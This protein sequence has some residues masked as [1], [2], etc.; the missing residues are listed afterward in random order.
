M[1]SSK[2]YLNFDLSLSGDE[3]QYRAKVTESPAGHASLNFTLPFSKAE[4]NNFIQTTSQNRSNTRS[5]DLE[6]SDIQTV[7]TLGN[8]LFSCLITGEIAERF[9]TSLAIADTQDKGLRIRFGFSDAP[10]LIDIPWEL[11]FDSANKKYIGLSNKTPIIRKLDLATLPRL[12]QIHGCLQVL[13]M[14]SSPKD[15]SP[16][17]VE[18]EWQQINEA[19]AELQKTNRIALTKI[20]PSLTSLQS[21]LRNDDYHVFHYIGHGGFDKATNDGV[22]VLEDSERNGHIVTA[23]DLG[24][25]LHD[26]SSL[27]LAFLNSCHGARTSIADPFAGVGQTLLQ[28]GMPAVIA[29]QFEITDDAAITF[30]SELYSALTV[31]YSIER[32]VAEGRKAISISVNKIEWATPVLYTSLEG[33]AL[34]H[35]GESSSKKV[36]AKKTPESKDVGSS[37]KKMNTVNILKTKIL[38]PRNKNKAIVLGLLVVILATGVYSSFLSRVGVEASRIAKEESIAAKNRAEQKSKAAKE[39]AEAARLAE[40]KRLAKEKEAVRLANK[41]SMAVIMLAAQKSREEKAK[42]EAARLAESKRLIEEAKIALNKMYKQELKLEDNITLMPIPLG[43]F[44]MG[45]SS[46]SDREQPVHKVTLSKPFWMSKTEITI[47]QFDLYAKKTKQYFSYWSD[48]KSSPMT[49]VNWF[50]TQRYVKWLSKNNSLELQCRLPSEAEWEYAAR[51][52]SNTEYPWGNEIGENNANCRGCKKQL[53]EPKVVNVGSF[54]E[55]S[56]GLQDMQGN[57]WE[58]VQDTW[59]KNYTGAPEKGEAWEEE[60]EGMRMV[61]GGSWYSSPSDVRSAYRHAYSPFMRDQFLGFRIVCSSVSSESNRLVKEWLISRDKQLVEEE[62]LLKEREAIR[63]AAQRDREVKAEKARLAKAND[64]AEKAERAK[65]ILYKLPNNLTLLPVPPGEFKMGS[66]AG[67]DWEKPVHKVTIQK[68]FWMSRTEITFEQY[69]AYAVASKVKLPNDEGSGRGDHPVFYVS[70][71]DAMDYTT[72]L[73]DNNNHSLQCRLPSEAEWEYAARAGSTTEYP[74]G[75][76][77]SHERANYGTDEPNVI[78]GLIKGRDKWRDT[79]PV[80]RFPANDWGFRDMHGNIAEWVLDPVHYD[81]KGAP[82][83][84]DSWDVGGDESES[85]HR[86]GSFFEPSRKIRS[87]YRQLGFSR[88]SR[89]SNIGFRIVCTPLQY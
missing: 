20:E 5:L 1:S 26:E 65:N 51:A 73:S 11:L 40:E 29:M 14:I 63:A 85:V 77:A 89:Q 21:E 78:S 54:P 38:R 50:D 39:T 86:G 12:R 9:R 30:S 15:H 27:Q 36:E 75:N 81:Y 8:K 22:L 60:D 28:N 64:L 31:G 3:N 70:W 69:D 44:V 41:K 43:D 19:T 59:H 55:N 10:T 82:D 80:G 49:D 79:A 74:W 37:T 53:D 34:I 56:W 17:N 88:D 25:M 57:V 23:Q 24:T 32:A 84:G 18:Q 48:S 58:W 87:A 67:L 4:L 71:H 62:R 35:R 76:E 2:S 6:P 83:N 33:G 46:G 61:R 45:S 13:V 72:W 66:N 47:E 42:I 16:L 7:E 68:P 52:G